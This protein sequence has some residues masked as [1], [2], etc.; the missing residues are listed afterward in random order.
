MGV[1]RSESTFHPHPSPP[2]S[3]GRGL[4]CD[5]VRLRKSERSRTRFRNARQ[6][7]RRFLASLPRRGLKLTVELIQLPPA[8]LAR[9]LLLDLCLRVARTGVV[10][11]YLRTHLLRALLLH[12]Q[13]LLPQGLVQLQLL[14]GL[15]LPGIRR[16]V[17]QAALMLLHSQL[18]LVLL[19]LAL[20]LVLLQRARARVVR[21]MHH[22]D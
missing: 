1:R 7:R 21:C 14:H 6:P 15:T 9:T 18:K 20:E 12:L 5:T 11:G 22:T 17:L 2:P 13:L 8:L 3:R 19:V 16:R 10:R 4:F